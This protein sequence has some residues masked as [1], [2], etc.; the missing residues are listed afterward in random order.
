MFTA[1]SKYAMMTTVPQSAVYSG[2]QGLRFAV[3]P[4]TTFTEVKNMKSEKYIRTA[5]TGY[6]IISALMC[7]LG[8]VFT[9]VPDLSANLIGRLFGVLI[10]LFGVIK[11]IGYFSKD[12]YRLAFQHDLALGLLLVVLGGIMLIDTNNVLNIICIVVGI[13][14]LLDSL[15]KIQIAIDSKRFGLSKWWLIMTAA[16]VTGIVGLMLII[17]PDEGVRFA[18][19]LLGISLIFEGILNLVT[20]LTAVKIM[21]SSQ[22]SDDIIDIEINE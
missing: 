8:I 12:L 11:L 18:T 17:R 20:A 13:Y 1:S 3:P 21:R 10:V 15:L 19:V 16:I 22:S 5:K 7:I 2:K 9:A 14:I 6:I 4:D